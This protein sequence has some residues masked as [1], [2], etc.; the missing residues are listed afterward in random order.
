VG[1]FYQKTR[2]AYRAAIRRFEGLLVDFPEYPS[3]DKVLYRLAQ[4]LSVMARNAEALPHL[5]R[6]LEEYP[7]SEVAK[8]ARELY[9]K[10]SAVQS[11]I[12]AAPSAS[13]SVPPSGAPPTP[14]PA[15]PP[16]VGR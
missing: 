11:G 15:S 2:K 1:Y 14:Q 4:C 8:D 6:L 10:L 5:A 7:E 9:H 12:P 3:M 13:P 16:P